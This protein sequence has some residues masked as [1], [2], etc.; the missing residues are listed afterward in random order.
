MLQA[1]LWGGDHTLDVNTT[2]RHNPVRT[3]ICRMAVD[4]WDKKVMTAFNRKKKKTKST[5]ANPVLDIDDID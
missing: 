5:V 4:D 3:D 2:T 1:T